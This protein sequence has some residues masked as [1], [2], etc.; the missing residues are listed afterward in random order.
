MRNLGPR[1]RP[2]YPAGLRDQRLPGPSEISAAASFSVGESVWELRLAR[3]SVP[4]DLEWMEWP[5]V[6]LRR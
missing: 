6:A 4:E 3:V 5:A 2:T 1:A